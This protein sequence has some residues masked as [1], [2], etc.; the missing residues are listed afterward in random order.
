[1]A[2]RLMVLMFSMFVVLCVAAPSALAWSNGADLDG[3]GLG[4]N[5]YGTHDWLLDNAITLAGQG[6]SWVDQ[7][8]AFFATDDPD[9]TRT[10]SAFHLFRDQG[11]G[12]GAPYEVA[13]LYSAAVD[14][15]KAG[16][17]TTA[18]KD[19]G[20][21]AHYYGD[22]LQPF[23]TAYAG[24]PY[25]KLHGDYELAVDKLT[26]YH[27]EHSDWIQNDGYKQVTDIRAET[28]LAA[29]FSRA[30]YP[31]LFSALR[32]SSVVKVNNPTVLAV[33]KRVLNRA[34]NDLADIVRSIPEAAGLALAPAKMTGSR[35]SV[36]FPAPTGKV[37]ASTVCLN[38][39]GKPIEGAAVY[40]TWPLR[41]GAKTDKAYTDKNGYA[42][43]WQVLNGL[44]LMKTA[45]VQ[46][47]SYAAGNGGAVTKS[48][49]SFMPS[50]VLRA[51]S[52]GIKTS[53]SNAHPK[54]N[55]RIMTSTIVHDTAGHVVVGLPV[56]FYWNFKSGTVAFK[57]V[58]D[59]RGIARSWRSIGLAA[60]GYRVYVRAQ[61]Q[62]G[63]FHRSSTASF[64][65][66]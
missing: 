8:T 40:F 34:S 1:M 35:M 22:I 6:G 25:D 30:Y 66:Q 21:L 20:L 5:G 18:S 27:G 29:Y 11:I 48:T 53:V 46:I 33:T 12:R 60:K 65:T 39:A 13:A 61:T 31:S 42:Y 2:R 44:P 38:A 51:G 15:Y 16:D 9:T 55:T 26:R 52:L 43:Y 64:V 47:A 36:Y 10:D 4:D 54:Q 59:A 63:G 24:L 50:P 62:S 14:A 7:Q 37:C 23:H 28:V 32:T 45:T 17:I 56:T 49:T 58:T 57:T 3:D 19:L 41:G